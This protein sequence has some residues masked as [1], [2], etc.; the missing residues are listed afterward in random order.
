MTRV[1]LVLE[2]TY[3][4]ITGGV[5]SWV[6]DIVTGLP[7]YEFVLYTISANPGQAVR[8]KLPPNVV[9]LEDVALNEGG[10]KRPRRTRGRRAAAERVGSILDFHKRLPDVSPRGVAELASRLAPGHDPMADVAVADNAWDFLVSRYHANNPMYAYADYYWAWKGSHETLFRVIAA[11]APAADIYHAVSTGYAGLAAAM[12]RNRTGKPFVLTEHGLYHKE[13]EMEVRVVEYLRGYQRDMW[14]SIYTSLS[15]IAY[16]AADT[17]ISLF[18]YNREK[19]IELGADPA[20]CAVIPN[21][22]DVPRFSS[23]ERRPRAGFNVGLVGRVVP[24]KDIRTFIATCK[25]VADRVPEAKFWCIGPEDEDPGYYAECKALVE[26]F[27]LGDRFTFTGRADVLE[28]YAFLDVLLL[29]SV[30]E[31]Q[32]LVIL[33]G[34]LAGVPTVATR[35]GNVPELL[36]FDDRFLAFSKDAQKL[37]EGVCYVHDHP[38][39]MAAINAANRRK[40]LDRYDKTAVLEAYGELYG[41]LAGGGKWPA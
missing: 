36:G 13:R 5:S 29:T 39:E 18:E 4:Y 38:G 9:G 25:I 20:R 3:P 26:T 2:G 1:C 31:A 37:A 15:R 8:Y 12:A 30:R 22:I 7:Q 28:Y 16:A 27:K 11:E 33:E 35:V 21:G 40:V 34:Y 41:V 19:Q 23:V 32:P 10:G 6:H 17:I 24:I 14:N